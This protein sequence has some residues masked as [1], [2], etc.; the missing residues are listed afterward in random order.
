MAGLDHIHSC[1]SSRQ[2][3]HSPNSFLAKPVPIVGPEL[4]L[5]DLSIQGLVAYQAAIAVGGDEWNMIKGLFHAIKGAR[6][7]C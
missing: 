6:F 3:V 1:N 5:P 2:F 7:S 4:S